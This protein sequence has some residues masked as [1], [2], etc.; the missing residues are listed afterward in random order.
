MV[1]WLGLHAFTVEVGGRS[2][3]GGGIIFSC[4][5][6]SLA[7]IWQIPNYFCI[8]SL[9]LATRVMMSPSGFSSTVQSAR[10]TFPVIFRIFPPKQSTRSRMS[11]M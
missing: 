4:R 6:L 10:S 2:I 7:L 9:H 5:E 3:L 11:L 1:Q 8:C